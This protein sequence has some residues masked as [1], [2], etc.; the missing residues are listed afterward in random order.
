MGETNVLPARPA[1]LSGDFEDDALGR[2]VASTRPWGRVQVGL[3]P[4]VPAACWALAMA[5]L[6]V[7]GWALV[8]LGTGW[9]CSGFLCAATSLGGRPA[10]LLVLSAGGVLATAVLA[11]LTGGLSR[12]GGGQLAA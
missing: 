7:S 1:L 10:L 2:F 12:A 9:R 4:E 6:A 11:A 3:A 5:N 8:V